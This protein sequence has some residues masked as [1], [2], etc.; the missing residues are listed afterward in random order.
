[1]TMKLKRGVIMTLIALCFATTAEARRGGGGSYEFM[2]HVAE[3]SEPMLDDA[4]AQLSLCHLIKDYHILY[5]PL[6]YQSEGYVLAPNRCDSDN[7]YSLNEGGLASAQADGVIPADVP[8]VP[9][10]SL[11]RRVP[12]IL[13][14][15]GILALI[16]L[17]I[18]Q[19]RNKKARF[20]EM[21]DLPILAQRVLDV[22]CH[23]AHVD[24]ETAEA[25]V[26]AIVGIARQ[27][28][29]SEIAPDRIHKMISL[30][31]KSPQD[32]HFKA[33]AKGLDQAQKE[34]LVRAALMVIMADGQVTKQEQAFLNKLAGVSGV[35]QQR[36]GEILSELQA[37]A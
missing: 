26:A 10:I 37:T 34:T 30:C 19:S 35:S 9:A 15:L 23:A 13:L 20:A 6:F 3:F 27:L 29:G 22:A 16:G 24:G 11:M 1:M 31:V 7:Y 8:A 36:F 25:E 28:T 12:T 5:I 4:G 14:G 21:G 18:R 33:F 32:A 17:G 2:D